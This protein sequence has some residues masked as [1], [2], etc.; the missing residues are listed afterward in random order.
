MSIPQYEGLSIER[1]LNKGF[2]HHELHKYLP[3]ERDID[4]LP[5]QWVASIVRAL[6]TTEFDA[7]VD[8]AVSR[9]N[10]TVCK[11]KKQTVMLAPKINAAF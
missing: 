8:E 11:T 2:E 4:R 3:E 1:I 9:R 5:R 7:W 6:L 10:D